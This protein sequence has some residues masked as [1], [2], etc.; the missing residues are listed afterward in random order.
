MILQTPAVETATG[1]VAEMY[2]EDLDE[3][4]FVYRHTAVMAINPEAHERFVDLVRSVVPS[5][6]LRVYELATLGAAR[7]VPSPHCLLA[8]AN[9]SITSGALTEEEVGA[10]ARH[11]EDDALPPADAAVV[12]FASRM[13]EDPTAMTDAD[14]LRLREVGF[15]DRQILDITLAAGVRNLFS[16]TL[17]ALAV[18]VE[19]VPGLDAELASVLRGLG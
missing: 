2:R 10:I 8:H 15:S 11:E 12:A 1:H 7:A 9:K 4:G 13:T 19:D 5:I 16:R 18:P 3:A 6:G 14:S 17:R